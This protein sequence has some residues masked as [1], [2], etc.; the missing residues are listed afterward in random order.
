[1]TA[2]G[3]CF[4]W[5]ATLWREEDIILYEKAKQVLYW[6]V[7]NDVEHELIIQQSDEVKASEAGSTPQGEIPDDHAGV[8]APPEK[9]LSCRSRVV[10]CVHVRSKNRV[11]DAL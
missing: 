2:T 6:P 8:E 10:G 5:V 3:V 11:N 7:L 4:N 1:M 9:E